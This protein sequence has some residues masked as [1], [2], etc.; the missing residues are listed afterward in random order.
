VRSLM[1]SPLALATR[2]GCA[3]PVPR[4]RSCPPPTGRR[5]SCPC[6]PA[7]PGENMAPRSATASTASA[8]PIPLAV[9]VVPS[10][11]S[12]AMSTL[13]VAGSHPLA[14]VEHRGLVL[15][16]L[17]DD[18]D[19]RRGRGCR[20]GPACRRRPPGRPP[21]CRPDPA[22]GLQP[23][24]RSRSPGQVEP[25]VAVGYLTLCHQPSLSRSGRRPVLRLRTVWP[26][27]MP[28]PRRAG[29]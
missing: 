10:T 16:A 5:R 23:S 24:P 20:D 26:R 28:P 6:R 2:G 3:R 12:T 4:D 11:G 15:L 18:D 13:P 21:P 22:S 27:P 17:A 8:P 19:A 7:T 25:Q 1:S 29:R 14:V 9:S